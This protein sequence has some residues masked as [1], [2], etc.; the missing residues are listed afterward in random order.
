M[1]KVGAIYKG[2]DTDR[3]G[4][5]L[6]RLSSISKGAYGLVAIFPAA[7]RST[8]HSLSNLVDHYKAYYYL[9][10]SSWHLTTSTDI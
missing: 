1:N 3:T 5:V 9:L 10:A 8:G 6:K 2:D 7:Y 4:I